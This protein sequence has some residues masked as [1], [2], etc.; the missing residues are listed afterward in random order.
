MNRVCCLLNQILCNQAQRL[1]QLPHNSVTNDRA[2]K[3]N[4]YT[5]EARII[6]SEIDAK[7]ISEREMLVLADF[8]CEA[9]PEDDLGSCPSHDLKWFIVFCRLQTERD[10]FVAML[11]P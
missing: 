4:A 2:V 6:C 7:G 10:R 9:I 1:R 8:L 3:P 11:D 5:F